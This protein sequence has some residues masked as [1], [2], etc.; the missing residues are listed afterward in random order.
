MLYHLGPHLAIQHKLQRELDER[1]GNEDF[2]A[3]TADQVKRLPFLEACINEGLRAHSSSLGLPRVVPEGRMTD[4]RFYFPE[5]TV[6]SIPSYTIHRD[7]EVYL[8]DRC[9][10]KHGREA[11]THASRVGVHWVQFGVSG[12]ADYL[13]EY[14]RVRAAGEGRE[15][16]TSE[17]A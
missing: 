11:C 16:K 9:P 5:R 2:L 10:K 7:P 1:L 6:V 8:P 13:C 14:G 12:A 15:L 4:S 17:G 3:A